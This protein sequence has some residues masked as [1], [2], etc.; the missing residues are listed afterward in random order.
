MRKD[1]AETFLKWCV[2]GVIIFLIAV[3]VFGL[4]G[5]E[6]LKKKETVKSDSTSVKKELAVKVDSTHSGS[7][8]KTDISE[9]YEKWK[10]TIVL[11]KSEPNVT[12]LH[13]VQI[14]REYEKGEKQETKTDSSFYHNFQSM[15]FLAIDSLN[16]KIDQFSKDKHSE[17]KG[18]GLLTVILIALGVVVAFKGLGFITSKYSIIKK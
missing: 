5:C 9:M 18:L 1:P 8:T 6:V 7:V 4:Y 17:T 12:N 2:I 3:V 13:P 10:E 14:I 11:P 16:R 15:M